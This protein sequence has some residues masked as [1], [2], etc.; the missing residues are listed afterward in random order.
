MR[1][2]G[3]AQSGAE[4]TV[5]VYNVTPITDHNE[6]THHMLEVLALHL[7]FT[8]GPTEVAAQVGSLL[9]SAVCTAER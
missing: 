9:L 3:S 8:R 5:T 4:K 7:H 1:V 6:I 2:F